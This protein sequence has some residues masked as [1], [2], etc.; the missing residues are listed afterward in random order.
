MTA[1]EEGRRDPRDVDAEFARMLEG[2]G[3]VLRPGRAPKEPAADDGPSA[4]RGSSS[5]APSAPSAPSADD[6]FGSYGPDSPAEPPSADARARARAA[7]PSAGGLGA[8]AAGG[9]GRRRRAADGPPSRPR[10]GHAE[11]D[12]DDDDDIPLP[13]DFIEPDP[14][15]PEGTSGTLWGW[16]ALLGGLALL[17]VVAVSDT[18]PVWLG[19]LGGAA[20]LGGLVALLMKVPTDRSDDDGAEV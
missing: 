6:A 4:G 12:G 8:G 19:W 14:D 17:L 2:E 11:L 1:P 18:L 13:G 16:T 3:M 15:L 9:A 7:H 10:T 20:A 5:S